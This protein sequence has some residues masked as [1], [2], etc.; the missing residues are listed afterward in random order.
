MAQSQ[1]V[2]YQVEVFRPARGWEALGNARARKGR[3][4][5]DRSRYLKLARSD[6]GVSFTKIRLVRMTAGRPLEI[7]VAEVDV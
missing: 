1:P 7:V 6:A 5:A 4:M 2:M 3:A